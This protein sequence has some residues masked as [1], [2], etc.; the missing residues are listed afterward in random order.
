MIYYLLFQ[1]AA[2][3]WIHTQG[4]ISM[5]FPFQPVISRSI[6]PAL[7][8][9][10]Y[11]QARAIDTVHLGQTCLYFPG[12]LKLRYLPYEEIQWAH[13]RAE[14]NRMSMC[15]GKTFVDIW[16]LL[17]YAHGK[18]V[19]K[20]EFQHK[21]TAKAALAALA[22]ANSHILIGYTDEIKASFSMA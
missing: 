15:C 10:D 20:I 21:E 6:D 19:A 14:E 9:Q 7:L 16:Y 3:H 11:V 5:H 22:E 13:L 18:Q 12:M 1:H 17:L 8:E 2:F 4:G